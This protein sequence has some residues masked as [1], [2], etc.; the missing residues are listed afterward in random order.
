[1]TSI[2]NS[3]VAPLKP[4]TRIAIALERVIY[5]ASKI[6]GYTGAALALPMMLLVVVDVTMRY[7]FDLPIFGSYEIVGF[8]LAVIIAFTLP[9]VMAIRAHIVIDALVVRI[10]QKVRTKVQTV[11]YF[12][13]LVTIGLVAWWSFAHT[14]KLWQV[15]QK[16]MLLPIPFA[17]FMFILFIG[18]VLF[19]FVVL[20]QLLY[21]LGPADRE[22]RNGTN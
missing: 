4:I 15:G 3:N 18:F 14:V 21:L 16:A 12:L 7:S 22:L 2:A 19:F 1:M 10:P 5:P 20:I 6:L 11:I 9:Y 8:I 17:P 13:C